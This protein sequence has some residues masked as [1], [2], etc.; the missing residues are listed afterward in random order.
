MLRKIEGHSYN[1]H[2]KQF[3]CRRCSIPTN[4]IYKDGN[5]DE[6]HTWCPD[7]LHLYN[8]ERQ[9]DEAGVDATAQKPANE[10]REEPKVTAEP[11]AKKAARKP[12][13][14]RE[15]KSAKKQR[16]LF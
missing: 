15:R 9:K 16:K 4:T 11:E 13:Q 6:E 2:V 7:C 12:P 8:A 10:K 14:P 1:S 3:Y 5:G